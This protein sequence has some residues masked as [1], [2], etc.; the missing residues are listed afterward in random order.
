MFMVG[1]WGGSKVWSVTIS[2][3]LGGIGEPEIL[4]L[5]VP[6]DFDRGVLLVWETGVLFPEVVL[7]FFGMAAGLL[8]FEF[9]FDN[10]AL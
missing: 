3:I 6:G 8:I 1:S 10:E 7:E 5:A 9:E 2:P 4:R